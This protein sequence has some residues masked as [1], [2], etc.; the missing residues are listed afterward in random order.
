MVEE[1]FL[2]EEHPG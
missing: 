1:S 2:Q